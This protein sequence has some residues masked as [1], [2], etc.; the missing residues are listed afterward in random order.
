MVLVGGS[1]LVEREECG[2]SSVVVLR[3][4]RLRSGLDGEVVAEEMV[5]WECW[6]SPVGLSWLADLVRRTE[7]RMQ[8]AHSLG[9]PEGWN[10][11]SWKM[12]C[13]GSPACTSPQGVPGV[14]RHG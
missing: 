13:D 5:R 4:G 1:L 11:W 2:S 9:E 3:S 7:R 6:W 10:S 14:G 8:S 12:L